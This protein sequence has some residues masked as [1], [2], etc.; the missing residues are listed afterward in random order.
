MLIIQQNNFQLK[1]KNMQEMLMHMISNCFY[2]NYMK[3]NI[4]LDLLKID[5]MKKDKN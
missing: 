1:I 2:K 5:L 3:K 4:N